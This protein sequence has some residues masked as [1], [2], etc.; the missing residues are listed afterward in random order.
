M[1]TDELVKVVTDELNL[2]KGDNVTVIDVKDRT[3]VTDFMIIVTSTSTRHANALC[4]YVSEKIKEL[5][6]RP[7]GQ[8]G[9]QGSDWVLLDLGDIIVHIMTEQSRNLYQLEKLWSLNTRAQEVAS[10]S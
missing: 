10:G 2:R 6:V 4:G 7:L 8:E 9:E 1:Q 5:G 3:S